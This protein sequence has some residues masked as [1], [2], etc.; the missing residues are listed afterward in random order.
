MFKHCSLIGLWIARIIMYCT[1]ILEKNDI[2]CYVQLI[3]LSFSSNTSQGLLFGE[4]IILS[5]SDYYWTT[6]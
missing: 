1:N 2:Y 3:H 6:Y 4:S 5:L